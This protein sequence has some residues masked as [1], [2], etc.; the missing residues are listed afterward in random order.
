MSVTASLL[1]FLHS[2]GLQ[3]KHF[4]HCRSHTWDTEKKEKSYGRKPTGWIW[5]VSSEMTVVQ[6]STDTLKLQDLTIDKVPS[7]A[8]L[9]IKNRSAGDQHITMIEQTQYLQIASL[10]TTAFHFQY[11]G[12]CCIS[13]YTLYASILAVIKYLWHLHR[14]QVI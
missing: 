13:W 8:T 2:P 14:L 10:L 6:R 7:A 1:I 9:I 4:Y 12:L 11:W 3:P 5:L